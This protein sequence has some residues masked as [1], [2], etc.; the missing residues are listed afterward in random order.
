MPARRALVVLII[1]LVA[2]GLGTLLWDVLAPGG[3]TPA[4]IVMFAAFAGTAPWTGLCVA[5]GLIGFVILAF[6]RDPVG[7]VFPTPEK[8]LSPVGWGKIG[9]AAPQVAIAMTVRDE[10]MQRVLPP[11]RRLL[12]DLDHTET[13]CAFAL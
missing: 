1:F 12:T 10:D 9:E 8:S 4:K 13:N 2:V 5:N 3:W 11:L 7:M 6:A